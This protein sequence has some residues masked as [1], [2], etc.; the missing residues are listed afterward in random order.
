MKMDKKMKKFGL[1]ILLLSLFASSAGAINMVQKESYLDGK[2]GIIG[3][4]DYPPFAYYDED[5]QLVGALVQPTIEI[6]ANQGI[7]IE[8]HSYSDKESYNPKV[9]VTFVRSGDMQLFAGA[10]ANT[11]L[12]TGLTMLYPAAVT[13]P[14]HIITLYDKSEENIRTD[15]DLKN[16]R[17]VVSASEYFND[18]ILQK[19]KNLNIVFVDTPF[20][21]YKKIILGE[22]DY[23]LG[24]LYYNKIMISRYGLGDYLTYSQK[25][26]FKMPIFV[27]MSKVTPYLSLYIEAF[28][29]EFSKPEY[30]RKV[31]EEIIRIINDEAAKNAGVV[32][33]SFSD[34]E[35]ETDDI[36]DMRDVE[37]EF[38]D[39]PEFDDNISGAYIVEQ[40]E[41]KPAPQK[42]IHDILDGI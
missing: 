13:N 35:E 8:R 27:A 38:D 4:P 34:Q 12:F 3:L 30:V 15:E 7:P 31:K 41:E 33:P 18:F 21:A 37:P 11:S 10:Y 39:K 17:G 36:E 2:L 32:P 26:L 29:N 23:M 16:L 42:T 19:I 25:P 9:L 14:I 22:A 6:M 28:K 24:S 1:L 20:D 5:N 40:Q